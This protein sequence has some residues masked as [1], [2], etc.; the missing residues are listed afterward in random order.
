MKHARIKTPRDYHSIRFKSLVYF[1]LMALSL[2]TFVLFF[3]IN[4]F[5]PIYQNIQANEVNNICEEIIKNYSTNKS[6]SEIAKIAR[7]H[8][9]D[10]LVFSVENNT[11]IIIY[12]GTRDFDDNLLNKMGTLIEVLNGDKNNI[13]KYSY[14]EGDNKIVASG[15][16]VDIDGTTIYFTASTKLQPIQSTMRVFNVSILF[17]LSGSVIIAAILSVTF[18]NI[19]SS[20]LRKMSATAKTL[21]KVNFD[22]KFDGRGYTE[23][24]QLADTLNYAIAELKKTDDLRNEVISN[25]SHELRTPLTMIKSYAELINDINGEDKIKREKDL[26]IIISEANRLEY[27]LNDMLDFSKLKSGIIEF[28]FEKFNFY[29]LL[30]KLQ[31]FYTTQH[32]Q[33]GFTF[34][35]KSPK[36]VFI[37]ADYKRIEQVITN[38]LNNA[39]NYSKENKNIIIELKKQDQDIY[40]LSI[41]DHGIGIAKENLPHIFDRHFRATNAKRVTVG[42]GIGLSIVKQILD[43]HQL[44]FGVLSEENKGSIF[45]INFKTTTKD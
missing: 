3:E 42:S 13:T 24:E 39:I 15:T 5:E 45:Y 32:S 12:N 16:A 30:A 31:E 27:L 20:P 35:L 40:R 25:V 2:V 22:A 26:N 36:N 34:T 29:S 1:L 7:E 41:I 4:F 44:N 14:E 19:I 9:V 33:N 21:D 6:K 10:V 43:A 23:V 11:G 8:E 18:S 37:Y 28:H 38:L 17:I